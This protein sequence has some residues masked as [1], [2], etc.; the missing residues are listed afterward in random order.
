MRQYMPGPHRLFLQHISEIANIRGYVVSH[1]EE[2][3][4][5]AAYNQCLEGLVAFRDK[6]VQLVSRY[7]V[8]QS[9]AA[10]R[11][12]K[13][14]VA[15]TSLGAAQQY[16]EPTQNVIKQAALGTGG[17]SPVVFLKQ[18]RDETRESLV[19]A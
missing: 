19:R 7:I 5:Q 3:S 17:T 18:V 14:M 13:S 11:S 16:K 4:L 10:Q 15:S 2:S 8:I 6:H 1:P 12:Q 9:R